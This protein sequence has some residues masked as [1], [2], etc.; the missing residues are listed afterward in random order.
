MALVVVVV[1]NNNTKK[2][3]KKKERKRK[4]RAHNKILATVNAIGTFL[5]ASPY[6]FLRLV[7]A[8]MRSDDGRSATKQQRKQQKSGVSN[9]CLTFR[10]GLGLHSCMVFFSGSSNE[11]CV[12]MRVC[13]SWFVIAHQIRESI[14]WARER[15][16]IAT[17]PQHALY[18][19]FHFKNI[20]VHL[21]R[22]KIIITISLSLNCTKRKQQK[23]KKKTCKMFIW[24]T[25]LR[26]LFTQQPQV[27]EIENVECAETK[28]ISRHS[29]AHRR[30]HFCQSPITASVHFVWF[31]CSLHFCCIFF[32][33][34]SPGWVIT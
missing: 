1:C 3:N 8:H 11:P 31:L 26:S 9:V 19:Q 30:H 28:N 18:L 10:A 15:R 32:F 12:C 5:F 4:F 34:C 17:S 29:Q 21:K 23:K 33:C 2:Q 7:V 20:R 6:F 25:F 24:H 16:R 27:S 22:Y 13:V 14:D